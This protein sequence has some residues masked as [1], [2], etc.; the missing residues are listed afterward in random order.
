E[1][2]Q[3]LIEGNQRFVAGTSKHPNQS[4]ARRDELAASQHPFATILGCSDSRVPAEMVFD[5]GFGDLFVIRVAGNIVAPDDLGS[6][7]YASHHLG[8][9]LIVVLGHEGCGGV[10]SALLSDSVRAKEPQ[11]IQALLNYI[12]PV[13]AGI[14][15]GLSQ[16]ERVHAAVEA[17]VRQSVRQ[18]QGTFELAHPDEGPDP[19]IVGAVYDLKTGKVRWLK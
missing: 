10:V 11:G 19:T 16:A 17:N 7:E 15:P 13:V 5:Q 1:G 12:E 6:I 4:R 3:R 14:D 8:V 18:L 9:P 2:L